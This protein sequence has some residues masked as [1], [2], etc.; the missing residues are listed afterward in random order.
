MLA[1]FCWLLFADYI[2]QYYQPCQNLLLLIPDNILNIDKNC[3]CSFLDNILNFDRI[4]FI[5]SQTIFSRLAK[6]PLLIFCI[7]KD[8]MITF[9]DCLDS[10]LKTAFAG[11]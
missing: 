1:R 4:A 7:F 6:F 8:C 5:D 2:G 3:F 9:A 11:C 10:I